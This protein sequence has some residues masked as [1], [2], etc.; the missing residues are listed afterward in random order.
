MILLWMNDDKRKVL[1][2]A[3]KEK[4]SCPTNVTVYFWHLWSPCGRGTGMHDTI[5]K[6]KP[7]RLLLLRPSGPLTR[8]LRRLQNLHYRNNKHLKTGHGPSATLISLH[9]LI[10]GLV[11]LT[12]SLSFSCLLLLPISCVSLGWFSLFFWFSW[13][14]PICS[15][16]Q[17]WYAARSKLTLHVA[18]WETEIQQVTQNRWTP[19]PGCWKSIFHWC[20]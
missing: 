20:C 1:C 5:N 10:C 11:H 14:G 13:L 16:L 4:T 15:G 7:G 12:L 18:I 8:S 9:P 17:L 3:L 19:D 6:C 2:F